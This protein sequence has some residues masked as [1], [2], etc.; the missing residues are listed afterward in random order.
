MKK[1]VCLLFLTSI[2]F[3]IIVGFDKN[4]EDLILHNVSKI[5]LIVNGNTEDFQGVFNGS[6]MIVELK[7]FNEIGNKNVEGITITMC[8]YNFNIVDFMLTNNINIVNRYCVGDNIVY[9]CKI[10]KHAINTFT[11]MQIA[12]GSDAVIIGLPMILNS[13]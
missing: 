3:A 4:I 8:N 5:Q 6:K 12:E 2:L 13:F 10:V 1:V 9:D 11:T 7:S